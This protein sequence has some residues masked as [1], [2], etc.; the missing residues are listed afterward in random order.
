MLTAKLTP[1]QP[2]VNSTGL[3]PD[4][5]DQLSITHKSETL[6]DRIPDKVAVNCRQDAKTK[7]G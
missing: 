2:A 7:V 4:G 1:P 5:H 6:L 3:L